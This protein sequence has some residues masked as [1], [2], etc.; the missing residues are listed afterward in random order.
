M[1]IYEEVK[2]RPP[3]AK[4][5]KNMVALKKNSP[6]LWEK[7]QKKKTIEEE[8]EKEC[9]KAKDGKDILIIKKENELY[10]MNSLYGPLREAIS[11]AEGVQIGN[12]EETNILYGL[13]NGLLV[14]EL[15]R[16][17]QEGNILVVFEPSQEVF[18]FVMK[19]YDISDIL[20]NSKFCLI[21]NDMNEEALYNVLEY[22]F[23]RVNCSENKVITLP[24]YIEVFAEEYKEFCNKYQEYQRDAEVMQNTILYLST[25]SV[26]NII[27][28]I[29]YF[30]RSKSFE[31]LKGKISKN[32]TAIMVAAGPSLKESLPILKKA[33]GKFLII[34]VERVLD[35]LLENEIEPDFIATLDPIKP[36]TP[37]MKEGN[38][39]IPAIVLPEASREFMECHKGDKIICN[40]GGL[41]AG[42]REKAGIQENVVTSDG[43]VAT[44]IFSVLIDI[45][46]KRIVFVG[47]DLAFGENK[48]YVDDNC[49]LNNENLFGEYIP[50]EGVNG[51]T[52]YSRLDWI[53]F[54]KF[55]EEN[56]KKNPQ[57]DFID[58]KKSGLKIHG[59]RHMELK[60]IIEQYSF[61]S[62]NVSE[63]VQQID[64]LFLEEGK[65]KVYEGIV[66][67]KKEMERCIE[68]LQELL[69]ICERKDKREIGK[70]LELSEKLEK[71]EIMKFFNDL[72]MYRT[73]NEQK[74]LATIRDND[75]S[76]LEI[77]RKI[78]QETRNILN[79]NIKEFDM[80][81]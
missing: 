43:S 9:V 51:E 56:I 68:L 37:M 6:V 13:G 12:I 11:W 70:I 77:M 72:I 80:Y 53:R 69:F 31:A 25:H 20:T 50:A 21:V 64:D 36:V 4:Y 44:F 45:G 58:V 33:K 29:K 60:D 14:R 48:A 42:L 73:I 41:Y 57:V 27:H 75:G 32:M 40:N 39:N 2:K 49:F 8:L 61:E 55:F 34:A 66:G 10:R 79:E 17:M 3:N 65:K 23:D 81:V 22:S 30:V 59:T 63:L 15:L 35:I 62:V 24:H 19:N 46:V 28:N 52:V 1:D 7:I 26:K 54:R 74:E 78:F 47:Q 5:E 67:I 76:M 71:I 18:R 38:I 16:H